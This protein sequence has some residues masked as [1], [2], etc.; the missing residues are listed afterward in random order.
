MTPRQTAY[1]AMQRMINDH[2]KR[3][4]DCSDQQV[5]SMA[6][7]ITD[8]MFELLDKGNK[9]IVDPEHQRCPKVK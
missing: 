6:A 1:Q 2:A 4:M 7:A 9:M 5:F 8:I 3:T